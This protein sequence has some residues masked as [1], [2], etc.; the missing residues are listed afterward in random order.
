MSEYQPIETARTAYERGAKEMR[1]ECAK[2]LLAIPDTDLAPVIRGVLA[3][4]I[5][6][7]PLPAYFP[8]PPKEGEAG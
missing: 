8:P 6:R 5:E 1:A 3:C 7:I 4:A 2:R